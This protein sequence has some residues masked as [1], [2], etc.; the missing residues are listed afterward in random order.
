[1]NERAKREA[2]AKP[3]PRL[4]LTEAERTVL[5]WICR[6]L[7]YKEIAQTLEC[8]VSAVRFHVNNLYRKLGSR[9]AVQAYNE[10]I[11]RGLVV[12]PRREL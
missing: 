1:M 12:P 2:A 11:R 5:D 4:M 3:S 7:G 6:G 10:A 8:S 9:N